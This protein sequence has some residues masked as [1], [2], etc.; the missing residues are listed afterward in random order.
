MAGVRQA[1]IK[2]PASE[3]EACYP[4]TTRT[5]NGEQ[6]FDDTAKEVLR[7]QIWQ[8]GATKWLGDQTGAGG[9]NTAQRRQRH[10][11]RKPANPQS[12]LRP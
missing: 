3:G 1:R 12:G 2:I 6:L 10:C 8:V 11:R 9:S 4:G 7:R 5:V